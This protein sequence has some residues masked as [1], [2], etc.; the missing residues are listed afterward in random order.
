MSRHAKRI[1]T[2]CKIPTVAC[3]ASNIVQYGLG[4]DFKYVNGMPVRYVSVP[5]PVA[6]QPRSVHEGYV[7]GNDILTGKPLMQQIVEQLTRP[8]TAEEKISGTPPGFVAEPRLLAADSEENLR[9]LF[10]DREWT[11]YNP[12][13]LPT[14]SRVTE[15]LKGTSRKPDEVIKVIGITGGAR[16]LTVE[17]AAVYAVMAGAKPEYFPLILAIA[18][19]APFGN[20]TTSMANMVVVSGPIRK[21]IGMNCGTN[22]MGPYNDAN[23][24]IGRAFTLMSKASGD[25]RNNVVAWESLG[26]T[27]QYNNVC[28]AENEEDLPEGWA[29]MHVQAGAK[30][31]DNVV[32]VGT[33]W[34][35]ISSLGES[36]R[37]YPPHM[38]MRDYMRALSGMQSAAT[39]VMDPTVAALLKNVY[40]FK[41]K[42][43]LSEWFS[44]NIE[45]TAAAYWG[46]GVNTTT[47]RALALQ[48]LEP[49][50]TW[51]KLPPD[52]LI[53]PFNNA[54]S[55]KIVVAGGKIQTTWF[56][57]DFRFGQGI[58]V[59]AW[60]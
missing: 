1:E 18:T 27:M 26:N 10:K 37:A 3:S 40:G 25:M 12:V 6:G 8:L 32:N 41:T 29:P 53:K 58:S 30:P 45:T 44:Q 34:S 9:Q 14:E 19:A 24:V 13:I 48:G 31:G 35:Y 55:I 59:D 21:K 43:Q 2:E 36:Q 7:A 4:Y 20:S 23:A 28:F 38:L 60:A 33:G 22:C 47:Y 16:P 39:V 15:V 54:K 5:F 17:K 46:N 57:T 42:E 56:V 49:Y 52:A 51:G 11:D 50:A